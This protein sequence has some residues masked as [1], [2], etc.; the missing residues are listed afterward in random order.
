M[1]GITMLTW[2]KREE[3]IKLTIMENATILVALTSM[4]VHM[5]LDV[6]AQSTVHMHMLQTQLRILKKEKDIIKSFIEFLEKLDGRTMNGHVNF[7]RRSLAPV[8]N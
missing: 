4:M 8:V 7:A 1:H 3:I 5:A 6:F 2:Q